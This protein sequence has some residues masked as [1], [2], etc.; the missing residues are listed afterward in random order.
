MD[1]A[2][3][4]QPGLSRGLIIATVVL[5]LS[6]NTIDHVK[7][8]AWDAFLDYFGDDGLTLWTYGEYVFFKTSNK[9]FGHGEA[10]QIQAIV[11]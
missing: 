8:L 4:K 11:Q 7:N 6:W 5:A 2:E 1:G 3:S 9:S 10:R